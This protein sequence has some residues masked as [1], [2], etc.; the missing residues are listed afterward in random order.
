MKVAAVAMVVLALVIGILP[1]FTDCESQGRAI[2][3]AAGT[4]IPMKCHWTGRA[5][6]AL[7]LP[8]LGVGALMFRARRKETVRN[9]G[10]L[11]VLMGAVAIL[12]P[13]ALIGVCGSPDMLCNAL[14]RP[15]LILSGSLVMVASGAALFMS[16][17]RDEVVATRQGP[18]AA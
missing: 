14:M 12:L 17:G 7:A 3:T 8:L 13:T 5:E 16:F 18:V 11:G 2:K 9:L 6:M 15:A 4:M 10:V 1:G